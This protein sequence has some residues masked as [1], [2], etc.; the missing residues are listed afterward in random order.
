MSAIERALKEI[1]DLQQNPDINNCFSVDFWDDNSDNPDPLHWKVTLIPPEGT[2]YEGGF[3]QLEVKLPNNYPNSKPNVKFL[4]KIYHCNVGK[5][6]G[7]IC[8]NTFDNWKNTYTMDDVLNHIIIL[9]YKQNPD[10]P[11]NS[12]MRRL[13]KDH[14]S[15]FE[16]NAREWVR[17]YANA[18]EFDNESKQYARIKE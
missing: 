15:D 3:F 12:E 17:I 14:L 6:N 18:D 5:D 11:M 16:K 1:N 10:S 2:F 7:A 13:Y 9:L 4:T 8:L